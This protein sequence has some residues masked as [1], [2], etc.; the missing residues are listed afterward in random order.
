MS[1]LF[2][3]LLVALPAFAQQ[4]ARDHPIT[5]DD[6]ATLAAITELAVSPDGKHVAYCEARWDTADDLRK[7]D[8]WVVPTDGKGKP[9]RLTGDRANDRHPK[10]S[11][12]GKAIYVLGNRKREAETKPPHDGKTQIWRVPLDGGEPRALTRVAGG[13]AAFDYA[14]K[15][16]TLFYSVNTSVTDQDDF[17]HLR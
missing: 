13:V 12:D 1:R 17:T 9:T 15:A 5:I 7:T 3:L 4:P 6:Y 2:A 16:G 11:A 8:L 14:P 10:W